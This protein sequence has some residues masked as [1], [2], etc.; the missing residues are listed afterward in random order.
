M[1][2][3]YAKTQEIKK[4]SF[5][6]RGRSWIHDRKTHSGAV[7]AYKFSSFQAERMNRNKKLK[8][9]QGLGFPSTNHDM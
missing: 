1:K 3:M 2:A 7:F 5:A 4:I 9:D 8:R 6:N